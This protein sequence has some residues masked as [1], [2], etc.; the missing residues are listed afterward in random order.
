MSPHGQSCSSSRLSRLCS[1]LPGHTGCS[2]RHRGHQHRWTGCHYTRRGSPAHHGARRSSRQ[3]TS[4]DGRG[5]GVQG[6]IPAMVQVLAPRGYL[7]TVKLAVTSG[8][9]FKNCNCIFHW[10]IPTSHLIFS[11]AYPQPPIQ[12]SILRAHRTS[13]SH[14]AVVLSTFLRFQIISKV[15]TFI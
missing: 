12:V 1:R 2:C 3:L 6:D 9:L 13:S 14:F 15:F 5:Q 11:K 7:D 10:Q 4:G 8:N